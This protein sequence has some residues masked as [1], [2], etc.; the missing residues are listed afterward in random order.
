MD[1]REHDDFLAIDQVEYSVREFAEQG[2]SG[3]G[4]HVNDDLR[5]R[6]RL[7]PG[8][9]NAHG[10]QEFLR[11]PNTPFAIPCHSLSNIGFGLWRKDDFHRYNPCR[12]RISASAAAHETTEPGF[13]R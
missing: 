7:N 6:L 5:R 13:C 9:H 8:K 10:Q 4:F 3:P 2:T 1:D 11:R 12:L